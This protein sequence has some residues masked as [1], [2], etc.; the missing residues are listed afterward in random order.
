MKK[1][2]V[3]LVCGLMM[4]ACSMRPTSF[5]GVSH[6]EPQTIASL[7][8]QPRSAIHSR[9]GTPTLSRNEQNKTLWSYQSD[10]CALLI[11][12]DETGICRH[13]ETRGKCR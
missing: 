5:E 6:A 13:A 1:W 9:F 7:I 11:F 10:S 12:F 8:G 4:S 2:V 3:G